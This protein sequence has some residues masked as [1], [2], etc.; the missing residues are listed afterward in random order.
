MFYN[1][2]LYYLL[3]FCTESVFGRNLV[4]GIWAKMFSVNQIAVFT[5][6]GCGESAYETLKFN[7]SQEW[8]VGIN[9]FVAWCYKFRK[10]KSCFNDIL[11]GVAFKFMIS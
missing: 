8:I 10:V 1:K 2:N 5:K 3:P 6:D 9:W 11:V 4:A 7:V